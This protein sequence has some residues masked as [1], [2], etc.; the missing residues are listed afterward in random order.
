M[1]TPETVANQ[2]SLDLDT[3]RAIVDVVGHSVAA[4]RAQVLGVAVRL[5]LFEAV[6]EGGKT[7]DELCEQLKCPPRSLERLLIAAHACKLLDREGDRYIPSECTAK[8]LVPGRPGYVGN[9]IRLMHQWSR[10]WGDLEQA[11]RTGKNVERPELH[12]GENA[13]Y[14]RDFILGMHDYAHYRGTDVL[15]FLD[16]TGCKKLIDVG[17]GPGTYSIMF[18]QQYP[19][20]AATIFDLPEVLEIAK[21]N[22]EE[23]SLSDRVRMQPGNYYTDELGGEYD[24]AFLS[25]MLHQESAETGKMIVEKSYRALASGG[26][27][28]IQAMFLDDD[29]SGPEWPALHNLLMLLIYEGGKA[30]SMAETIPWLE[31]A[32]FVD[33]QRVRMSF[34]NVNSLIIARKP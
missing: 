26:R 27:I 6:A 33:V 1:T 30:Y 2:P 3:I 20:L 17:G 9:W 5:G 11:V 7:V 28:V 12:L 25:D 13:E 15:K 29:D 24:V 23:A 10:A 21:E 32:G 4:W 14:T 31:Q 34:Y 16:L 18:C 22:V 19:E 8:T